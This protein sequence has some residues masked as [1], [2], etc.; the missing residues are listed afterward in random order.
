VICCR[1]LRGHGFYPVRAR[2]KTL[3][4]VGPPAREIGDACAFPMRERVL[5]EAERRGP[6]VSDNDGE[7]RSARC[8]TVDGMR[9]GASKWA[10]SLGLDPPG[11]SSL[12]FFI[13][14]F[15]FIFF[16]KSPIH[17][18]FKFPNSQISIISLM[19]I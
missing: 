17:F 6:R 16:S 18:R 11:G 9:T 1:E 7:N 12:S 5:G 15:C 4:E 10:A 3:T 13:L 8:G 2:K 14:F 19:K